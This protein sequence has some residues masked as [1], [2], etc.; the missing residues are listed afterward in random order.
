MRT[1]QNWTD[2]SVRSF[3]FVVPALSTTS[4][5]IAA[6]KTWS[7][8]AAILISDKPI[9]EEVYGDIPQGLQIQEVL[10]CK[11]PNTSTKF[12]TEIH[13]PTMTYTITVYVQRDAAYCFHSNMYACRI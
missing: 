4:I 8:D 10:H 1:Y 12:V 3:N 13:K 5:P 6:I 11:P 2:C 7:E 9:A